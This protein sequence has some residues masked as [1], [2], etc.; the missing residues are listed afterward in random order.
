[1]L[2][3]LLILDSIRERRCAFRDEKCTILFDTDE[4]GKK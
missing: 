2:A 4:M 3:L 1:M